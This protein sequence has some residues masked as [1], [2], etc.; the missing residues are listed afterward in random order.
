MAH[1]LRRLPVLG[2]AVHWIGRR[3]IPPG[4]HVWAQ[5]QHGPAA[6]LWLR[7]DPRTGA[8]F[9]RGEGELAV[10]RA[11]AECLR[12]GMVFYDIGANIGFF[13][14]LGARLVGPTGRVFAFE[15]EPALL[16]RLR[17]NIERNGLTQITTIGKAAAAVSGETPFEPADPRRSPD[18]GLGRVRE[19]AGSTTLQVPAV[20]LNDFVMDH[21]WPDVVKCDVEGAE[22]DVLRGATRL[23]RTRR[24]IFVIEVHSA[25]LER[26]ARE[27][28]ELH[29]Y[30]VTRL[31]ELHLFARG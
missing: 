31:D 16:P 9:F 30:T 13:S 15:P 18:F 7:V 17:E 29:G 19:N 10:Q 22:V 14:L 21:P 26:A 4:T 25:E 20:S 11:L 3:L 6:G 24:T 1:Q 5:V 2:Q 28:L 8:L 12:S 23:L 27:L